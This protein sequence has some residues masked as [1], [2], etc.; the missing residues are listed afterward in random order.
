[1]S[2]QAIAWVLEHSESKI[3]DRLVLLA[4]A[5]HA[6][7][8]GCSAWPS[9]DQIAREARVGRSTVFECLA[10]L[11]DLGELEIDRGG[12]GPRST[13]SY[14]IQMQGSGSQTLEG[15][16]GSRS[17]TL[18]GSRSQTPRVQNPD[19]RVQPGNHK[20]SLTVLEPKPRA[21]VREEDPP[22]PEFE[23][24]RAPLTA[25]DRNRGHAALRK[26]RQQRHL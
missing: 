19:K 1:V 7:A 5:N 10:R 18:E 12:R 11:V 21:H 25:E 15:L 9:V 16:E 2:I 13:N 3:A 22:D 26:L 6:D 14:R 23:R 24:L 20:P 17:Q 4:I 8:H